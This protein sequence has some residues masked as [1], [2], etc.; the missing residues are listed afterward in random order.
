MEIPSNKFS[1]NLC[2]PREAVLFFKKFGKT[3]FH[4]PLHGNVRETQ[5]RLFAQFRDVVVYGGYAQQPCCMSG[6]RTFFPMIKIYCSCN[7]TW[8]VCK[9]SITAFKKMLCHLPLE[10]SGNSN[11]HFWSREKRT[12]HNESRATRFDLGAPFHTRQELEHLVFK[13]AGRK[14]FEGLETLANL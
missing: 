2:F 5:T 14:T 13:L 4:L 10:I 11:R 8:L 7:A 12:L 6:K 9:T 1:E 3:R